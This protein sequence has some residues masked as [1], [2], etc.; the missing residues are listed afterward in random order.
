MK[1]EMIKKNYSINLA[2][3]KR[4]NKCANLNNYFVYNFAINR[5]FESILF[6]ISSIKLEQ[7]HE[8]SMH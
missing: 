7:Q 5:H 2:K 3:E 6:R 4:E 8:L 1:N